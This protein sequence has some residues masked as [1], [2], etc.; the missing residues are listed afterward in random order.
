MKK[1]SPRLRALVL[2]AGLGTRLRPLTLHQPKPLL[3]VCGLP[4]VS[5][6]LTQLAKLGCEL[7]VLNLHHLPDALPA[8]LGDAHEG[9]ALSYSRE[10]EI[11]GTFGALSPPRA[12]LEDADAVLLINGDSL[13]RWPLRALVRRHLRS[14]ADATLL[15]HRRAPDARLG[16]GVGVDGAGRITTLRDSEPVGETARRHV[17]AGAHVLSPSLLQRAPAREADIIAE[18]YLPLLAEGKHLASLVMSRRWHDLGTPERYLEAV[19]DTARGMIPKL[20]WRGNHLGVGVEVEDVELHASVVESGAR[21]EAGTRLEESVVLPGAVVGAGSRLR[22]VIVGPN[23]RLP[24]GT[25]LERRLVT[26][27]VT[28]GAAR[29]EETVLGGL[30]YT[31]LGGA[32]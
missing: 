5:R 14:G 18:L 26:R 1:S 30:V 21:L 8:A 24:P 4:L 27:V 20:L 19:L 25:T 29:P 22:H 23:V 31:P 13:C 11:L 17:F 7:A 6:T 9:M 16:G 32:A 3:P 12:Q 28:G 10:P 2:T 15:L